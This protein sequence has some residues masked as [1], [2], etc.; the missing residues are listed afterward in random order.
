LKKINDWVVGA[1]ATRVLHWDE[2][3]YVETY[4]ENQQ[5]GHAPRLGPKLKDRGPKYGIL[6]RL[7]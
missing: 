4:M 2:G 1:L 3:T 7:R 5:F 6:E